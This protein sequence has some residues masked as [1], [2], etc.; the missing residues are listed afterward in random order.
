MC[1]IVAD[2]LGDAVEA[3]ETHQ[4]DGHIADCGHDLRGV[5]RAHPADVFAIIDVTDP[6]QAILDPPVATGVAGQ[7]LG[8]GLG[9][10]Q[11]GDTVGD[12]VADCAGL[13]VGDAAFDAHDLLEAGQ[14]RVASESRAGFNRALL[15]APTMQI[16]LPSLGDRL[17][18]DSALAKQGGNVIVEYRLI[19]LDR[20]HILATL[21]DHCLGQRSTGQAGITGD[22]PAVQVKPLQ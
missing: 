8:I 19:G 9:R 1:R 3:V 13:F 21:V 17:G 2:G 5:A 14:L 11:A 16:H 15:D 20:Q 6:M 10:R 7:E 12:F 22:D 18:H 4:V